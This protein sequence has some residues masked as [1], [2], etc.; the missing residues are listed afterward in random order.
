MFKDLSELSFTII[1][2]KKEAGQLPRCFWNVK[3]TGDFRTDAAIGKTLALEYLLWEEEDRGGP[4]FL[5]QIVN[6][7]PKPLT[8]VEDSFLQMVCF[9]AKAA[10]GFASRL[11][12]YWAE[13]DAQE[14]S[15]AGK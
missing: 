15:D 5:N 14:A 2:E 9:Q 12:A 1:R 10:R 13:C 11:A 7:M 4:G 6:D 3:A 8:A